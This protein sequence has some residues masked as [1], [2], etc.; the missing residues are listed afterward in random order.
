M[1]VHVINDYPED[2][3]GQVT[4]ALTREG[5]M[6]SLQQHPIN[7]ESFGKEVVDFDVDIPGEAGNYTL[8]SQVILEKDTV[9]STRYF[10]V[11]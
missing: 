1:P 5:E 6:L 7:V 10:S 4:L 8:A 3:P 9:V 11:R 2:W